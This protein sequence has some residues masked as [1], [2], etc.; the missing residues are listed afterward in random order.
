[1]ATMVLCPPSQTMVARMSPCTAMSK[2]TTEV[3]IRVKD[4]KSGAR[5]NGT[6]TAEKVKVYPTMVSGTTPTTTAGTMEVIA[7]GTTAASG[8]GLM[9][10]TGTAAR[11]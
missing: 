11:A 4:K 1:M 2:A 3:P 7:D 10:I 8:E 6:T 5:R 9:T